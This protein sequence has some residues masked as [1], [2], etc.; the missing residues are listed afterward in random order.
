MSPFDDLT[1]LLLCP[2]PNAV[3]LFQ[4]FSTN[5]VG[6]PLHL[7]E[8]FFPHRV[9]SRQLV[10]DGYGEPFRSLQQTLHLAELLVRVA[11][12]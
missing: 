10:S 5:L 8:S 3:R 7:G 2:C 11:V 4:R 9:Q 1:G 6:F 12:L